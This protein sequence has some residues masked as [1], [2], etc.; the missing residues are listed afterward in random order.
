MIL[1]NP[2]VGYFLP[3]KLAVY[4]EARNI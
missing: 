3:C 2:L 4:E 1:E